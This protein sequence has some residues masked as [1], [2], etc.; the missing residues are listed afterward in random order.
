MKEDRLPALENEIAELWWEYCPICGAK[1]FNRKC[2]YL[3]SDPKCRFFMS[4]SEFDG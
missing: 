2:R 3:C 1:M 4:C